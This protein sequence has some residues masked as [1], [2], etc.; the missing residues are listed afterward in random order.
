MLLH[1]WNS[2]DINSIIAQNSTSTTAE[3]SA[4][5]L[6]LESALNHI[7][8]AL[9]HA[10]R[11]F[12]KRELSQ[13]IST[14]TYQH[15]QLQQQLNSTNLLDLYHTICSNLS[16][17]HYSQ[18][19]SDMDTTVDVLTQQNTRSSW[20]LNLWLRTKLTLIYTSDSHTDLIFRQIEVLECLSAVTFAESLT[21][22]I[23]PQ[24]ENTSVPSHA[25]HSTSKIT[26]DC[27]NNPTETAKHKHCKRWEAVHA[28]WSQYQTFLSSLSTPVIS[29][30]R[31]LT[32][33]YNQLVPPKPNNQQHSHKT[34]Y[35]NFLPLP[36]LSPIKPIK[37]QIKLPILY[38]TYCTHHGTPSIEPPHGKFPYSLPLPLYRSLDNRAGIG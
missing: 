28:K 37:S 35:P 12:G 33:A 22:Q 27:K 34:L 4:A 38:F 3:I 16:I 5:Q 6:I 32:M 18:S 31:K 17:C 9:S 11:I 36:Y 15:N 24:L 23:H 10:Y 30:Q 7:L 2:N 14:A 1:E 20:L 25:T 26:S 19:F 29:D 8:Y 13:S 21:Y